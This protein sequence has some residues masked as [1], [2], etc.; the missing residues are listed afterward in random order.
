MKHLLLTC[1]VISQLMTVPFSRADSAGELFSLINARLALMKDVAAFKWQA[2]QPIEDLAREQVVLQ[3]A[4]VSALDAGLVPTT[5]LDF[6]QLQMEAAKEIQHYWFDVYVSG[7]PPTSAPD[8][9][10]EVR[11][12]LL[13][14]GD[15]ILRGL[16]ETPAITKY[17]LAAFQD[18]I[19][20]E[21][22]SD[23]TEQAL[24]LALTRVQ[25]FE[26]R[27]N[28]VLATGVL[29][30]GTTGDY[31]PFSHLQ[32][33]NTFE[34]IDIDLAR[35]LAGALGVEATFIQTS[36]PT[37]MNDLAAGKF[38]I[39]MSGISRNT[40]RQKTAFFSPPY[41]RG[42]KTPIIRCE[43]R[44][45]LASLA[46]INQPGVRVIVN[47]G[48]TNQVFTQANIT[49][50][51]V[52]VFDDNTKIFDEIAEGRADVMITDAI[53]VRLKTS[54]IPT[55]CAAMPGQTLTYLEKAYLLPQDIY[56]KEFVE[57]WLELR[58]ADGTVEH[59]M[60]LHLPASPAR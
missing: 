19:A 32:D 48:G 39:G 2:D 41:Y 20:I 49:A 53:E 57:T 8:L 58:I 6:F 1:F 36:W 7:N 35:D 9:N 4:A 37:L 46:Q 25:R 52:R 51:E 43:D 23:T 3:S 27:L 18:A 26:H 12:R 31:A 60:N 16:R 21:G 29:R 45:K 54:Q 13:E 55:L 10:A 44:E 28:Q 14:L 5:S 30:I 38:D 50:A 33:D 47:P 34:G 56:L 42:G 24:F 22:L 17:D 40:A 15:A 59:V 11:P